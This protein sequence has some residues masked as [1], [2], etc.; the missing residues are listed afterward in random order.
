MSLAYLTGDSVLSHDPSVPR[1]TQPLHVLTATSPGVA[2]E[3]T[4]KPD[5]RDVPTF[6]WTL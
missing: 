3:G 5:A 6:M 1:S 4:M 2:H